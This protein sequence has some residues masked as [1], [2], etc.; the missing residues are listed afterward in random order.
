MSFYY[1]LLAVEKYLDKSLDR[2][3][4]TYFFNDKTDFI[5][6]SLEIMTN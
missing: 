1:R 3:A 4:G 5:P 6:C 2:N